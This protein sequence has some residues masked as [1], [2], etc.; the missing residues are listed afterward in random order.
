MFNA[1]LNFFLLTGVKWTCIRLTY[2]PIPQMFN[3]ALNFFL[4]TGV[5]WTCIRAT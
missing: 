4:L 1:A 3:A 2:L 5:K